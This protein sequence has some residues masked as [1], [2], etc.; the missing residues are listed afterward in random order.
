VGGRGLGWVMV[1]MKEVVG[2]RC[3]PTFFCQRSV[4]GKSWKGRDESML[5][6]KYEKDVEVIMVP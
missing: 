4:D 1:M 2:G 6:Y 5:V 3:V